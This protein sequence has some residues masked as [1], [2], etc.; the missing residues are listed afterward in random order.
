[1]TTD[2]DS[3]DFLK[4]ED[5]IMSENTKGC[6]KMKLGDFEKEGEIVK[7]SDIDM[8]G[9]NKI[10]TIRAENN[11]INEDQS[12]EL[13]LPI[14]NALS[15]IK[16]D[17]K[18]LVFKSPVTGKE[19]YPPKKQLT[20]VRELSGIEELTMHYFRHILVTAMGEIGTASTILSASLGHTNLE[21]VTQF[22]LSANHTKG[23]QDANKAI[24]QITQKK[25]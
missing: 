8:I 4:G 13:P 19:L 22:Y 5:E 20:K 2:G 11:K 10:Y 17:R 25:S 6:K 24:E 9:K 23:S 15:D 7:W 12:Y 3:G 14:L 1:M 16:D 18:G 21:T